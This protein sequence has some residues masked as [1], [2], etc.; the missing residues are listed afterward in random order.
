M[1]NFC[2]VFGKEKCINTKTSGDISQG[3]TGNDGTFV[4]GS[5]FGRGLLYT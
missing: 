3:I 1:S 4:I 5:Y 2:K